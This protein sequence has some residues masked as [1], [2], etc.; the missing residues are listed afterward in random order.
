VYLWD[1]ETGKVITSLQGHTAAVLAL[2]FSPKG[3]TLATGSDDETVRLWDIATGKCQHE[4]KGVHKERVRAVAYSQDGRTL[5]S[6]G[7]DKRVHL[8]NVPQ[9]G[10]QPTIRRPILDDDKVGC[11]V[12]TP[13]GQILATGNE[14]GEVKLWDTATG[15]KLHSWTGHVKDVWA[16]A[17]TPDGKTLATGGMDKS[18]KLWQAATG[19]HLLTLSGH[20]NKV[21]GVAFSPDGRTLAT[22]DHDGDVKLWQAEPL[23]KAVPKR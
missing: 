1:A 8:Y 4:L 20:N 18:V 19:N 11:A 7:N 5:V 14:R 12:F 9:D 21:N 16:L 23:E 15:D 13:D 2:A 6:A 17:F 22:A 3:S 10:G